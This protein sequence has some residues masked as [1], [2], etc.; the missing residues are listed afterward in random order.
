VSRLALHSL[1]NWVLLY[2][3]VLW[4]ELVLSLFRNEKLWHSSGIHVSYIMEDA[5]INPHWKFMGVVLI[6]VGRFYTYRHLS[7]AKKENF[8]TLN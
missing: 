8:Q 2:A 5:V 6:S 3:P 1:I 4:S 7:I